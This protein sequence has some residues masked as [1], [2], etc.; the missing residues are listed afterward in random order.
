MITI[1][2]NKNKKM[3]KETKIKKSL[4]SKMDNGRK[5]VLIQ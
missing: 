4:Q 5:Q 2:N 3:K 1:D